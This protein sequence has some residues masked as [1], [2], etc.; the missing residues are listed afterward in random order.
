MNKSAYHRDTWAEID[1]QAIK[2]NVVEMKNHL[3]NKEVFAVVKADAYGHGEKEVAEAALNAGASRLAVAVFDEALRL[4][5]HFPEVPILVMGWTAPQYVR[6]AA[7]NN[8]TLT[9]FQTEWVNQAKSYLK[10][11]PLSIHLKVDTGMGRIGIR[12]VEEAYDVIRA[13]DNTSIK[14]T[15][16]FTHFATADESD[17]LYYQQQ[18]GAFKQWLKQVKPH[19]PDDLTVHIGNSAA[20]M[21]FPDD[22]Y[23]GVRFGISMYGLYPSPTVKGEQPIK[24]KPAFSLYSRLIHVKKVHKGDAISYGATYKAQDEEWIGTIPI[25]YGDGWIRKLQDFSA[26]VDGNKCPIV[27]RICM[28]QSMIKLNRPY[29]LGTKVTLI[30]EDQNAFVSMDDAAEHLETINYE[31]PCIL[32]QRIPRFYIT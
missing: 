22:M 30:G 24:L 16:V 32:G 28:D 1:L 11:E 2:H 19:L 20:A 10:G 15:G 18:L 6:L 14:I 21:R 8:I 27:G 3:N 9:A 4:R 5:E 17:L 12:S 31:I 26:L 23:D 7:Q 25:G 29:E 13:C